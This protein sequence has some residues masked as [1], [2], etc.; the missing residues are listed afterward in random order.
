M[1][2]INGDRCLA[3]GAELDDGGLNRGGIFVLFLSDDAGLKSFQKV[4]DTAG[5]FT[6]LDLFLVFD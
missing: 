2:D 3:I 5:S 6:G 1:A 4:S